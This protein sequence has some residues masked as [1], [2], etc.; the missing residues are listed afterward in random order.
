MLTSWPLLGRREE[1]TLLHRLVTEGGGGAVVLSGAAGVGKTRL[2]NEALRLATEAGRVTAWVAASRALAEI[3]FG[4]FAHLLPDG[5]GLSGSPLD[6][7]RRA[8]GELRRRSPD[9]ALVL[10]VDDAHLLDDASAGLVHQLAASGTAVVVATVRDGAAGSESVRVLWRGARV[11]RLELGP[12]TRA[13]VGELLASVLAG[14]VDTATGHRMWQASEGNVL[15]LRELVRLGTEQGLLARRHGVWSWRGRLRSSGRL[16]ELIDERLA[17][18]EPEHRHALEVLAVGEPLPTALFER[19]VGAHLLEGLEAEGLAAVTPPDACDSIQLAHPLYGEAV[20]AQLGP[21]RRRAICRELAS[22]GAGGGCDILRLAGW[23]LDSG[24]ELDAATLTTAAGRASHLGDHHLAERFAR[25]AIAGGGGVTPGVLLAESLQAQG[26]MAEC[27]T[28]LDRLDL[29]SAEPLER[30]RWAITAATG[31]FWGDSDADRAAAVLID[32]QSEVPA[33]DLWDELA[34]HRTQI[35]TFGGRPAE[36][37]AVAEPAL[38]RMSTTLDTRLRLGGAAVLA[39]AMVGQTDQAIAIADDLLR[40]PPGDDHVR[41]ELDM[42]VAA[43]LHA[44]CLAGRYAELEALATPLYERLAADTGSDDLRGLAVFLWGRALL[45]RGL[46]D[47]AR[48]RLREA[49]ALL[50]E[51]DLFGQLPLL[52]SV[53]AR[54]EAQLGHAVGAE[55]ALLEATRRANPAVKIHEPY[56]ALA[57]AWVASASGEQRRARALARE[58]ADRAS[59]LGSAP[60]E[61]EALHE[62]VRLGEP[63][64]HERL[65][66]VAGRVDCVPAG[67][68]AAHAAAL[69]ARDGSE[70]DACAARFADHGLALLAA[71][72]S[73]EAAEL[74]AKAGR[75]GAELVALDRAHH[76]SQRCEGARSPVLARGRQAPMTTW[77]TTR[78]REIVELANRGLSNADIAA[79]LVL[80]RRTVGNHLTHIY[81]KLQVANRVELATRLGDGG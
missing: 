61:L 54:V 76:W 13:V 9:R 14:Q 58:A 46:V 17:G 15:V 12:L 34:G 35:L 10:G 24:T 19:V 65:A 39:S 48:V 8:H 77:L 49:A 60:S 20:R 22:E 28:E 75:R 33:G 51:H 78:E 7:L 57:R 71:E 74:H 4:A 23:Q 79:R 72:A 80:S 40:H 36:A 81:D 63:G 50:R 29:V 53:L 30:T 6:V 16:T 11:E 27:R 25:A 69:Q 45:G 1:M 56:L 47:S 42:V 44:Y 67:D 37:L 68:Y 62:A 52:L 26:R 70:L 31:A 41:T 32:A 73:V 21:L 18:L 5:P 38:R 2:A 64:L 66:Q 3:P 59:V 43:R 55:A